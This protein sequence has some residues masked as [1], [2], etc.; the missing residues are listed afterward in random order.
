MSHR[1]VL[2]IGNPLGSD[3]AAGPLVVKRINERLM[4]EPDAPNSSTPHRPD[5]MAIDAGSAPESYTSVIRKNRP[6]Q[7][8][9]V[10]AADMGLPPG[11]IRLLSM[12]QIATP[13]FSTHSMPLSTLVSYVRELC[14]E[15]HIIGIQPK[16]TKA[17]NRISLPVRKS[18]E[19]VAELIL[20][21]RLDE[22]RELG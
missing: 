16:S 15:V 12:E 7:L 18:S 4:A 2:G 14:G 17:G 1:I 13:S 10:D 3:D 8:I 20:K 9:L 22:I 19:R 21:E 6:E 5:I 11:S